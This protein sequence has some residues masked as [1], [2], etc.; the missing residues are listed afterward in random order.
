MPP[1]LS[2][3]SL[4]LRGPAPDLNRADTWRLQEGDGTFSV[5]LE[6]VERVIAAGDFRAQDPRAAAIQILSVTHGYLLLALGGLITEQTPGLI[7]PL[8]VNLMVGLGADRNKAER[9]L[10]L[11]IGRS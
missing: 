5:L 10:Q 6:A 2:E 8:T 4:G 1:D 11:A 9:S 7:A 3:C